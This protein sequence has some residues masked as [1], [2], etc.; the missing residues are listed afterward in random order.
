MSLPCSS[1][2][3]FRMTLLGS[4]WR[5]LCWT[6]SSSTCRSISRVI[7][8]GKR[9]SK[10]WRE[11]RSSSSVLEVSSTRSKNHRC[12]KMKTRTISHVHNLVRRTHHRSQI[13]LRRRNEE[14]E[15]LSLIWVDFTTSSRDHRAKRKNHQALA[16]LL[17]KQ[18]LLT[19]NL[20]SHW[21]ISLLLWMLKAL[22]KAQNELENKVKM[23]FQSLKRRW[24]TL[25]MSIKLIQVWMIRRGNCLD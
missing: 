9:G 2:K 15:N 18:L 19:L 6:K 5:R 8:N 3:L 23:L 13:Q 1:T 14:D 24:L 20:I 10:K 12:L 25:Q 21:V 22:F 17:L 4:E 11:S 16:R 7:L